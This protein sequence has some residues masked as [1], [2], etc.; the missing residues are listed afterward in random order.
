MEP[1]VAGSEVATGGIID[2]NRVGAAGD[3]FTVNWSGAELRLEWEESLSQYV[4]IRYSRKSGSRMVYVKDQDV[5]QHHDVD[6]TT[7]P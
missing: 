6:P 2:N 5:E 3:L 4:V 1:E 7:P